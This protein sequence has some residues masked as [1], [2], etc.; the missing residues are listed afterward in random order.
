[1]AERTI[2]QLIDDLDGSDI[3]DG[4]GQRVDFAVRG[5]SYHL[6]LSAANAATFDSA[7]APFVAAALKANGQPVTT[8]GSKVETNG[9]SRRT[10][11]RPRATAPAATKVTTNVNGAA[12]GSTEHPAAIRDWAKKHGHSVSSRGRIAADVVAA[13]DAAH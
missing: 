12:G 3:T 5:I 8:N 6:D 9:H 4:G 10:P 1:M 7:L 11:R 2:V 13:F